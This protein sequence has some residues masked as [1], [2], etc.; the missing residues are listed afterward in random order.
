[1]T[2]KCLSPRS[3]LLIAALSASA[4]LGACKGD[5]DGGTD[6]A[7][8][9][10]AKDTGADS[11]V[12]DLGFVDTGVT[13]T[14]ANEDAGVNLC[15]V[16][17]TIDVTGTPIRV[18]EATTFPI[19]E[20]GA[21][22]VL[23]CR[24]TPPPTFADDYCLVECVDF[25]GYTPTAEE[26]Q[27]IEVA[28]F[29]LFDLTTMT[30]VSPDP[31]YD[32][33]TG[34]DH[35]PADRVP[36]GYILQSTADPQ[37]T[38]GYQLELGFTGGDGAGAQTLKAET[39][40]VLRIRSTQTSTPAWVDTYYWQFVRRN[41]ETP[42]VPACGIN[43]ARTPDIRYTFPI[44]HRSVLQA[45]IS[46]AGAPIPGSANLDDGFG[47][48]YAAL[49]ARDCSS[50]GGIPMTNATLGMT[51][52]PIFDVYPG[53][54][55]ELDRSAL[56]T[57]RI[58]QWVGVGFSEMTASSSMAL[59]VKAAVGVTTN[60]TCTQAFAGN[61]FPVYPDALTFV[62]FNRENAIVP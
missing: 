43:E 33:T 37:C 21:D 50:G 8:D 12:N 6:A 56:F 18:D 16:N 55:Y 30:P 54:A 5:D 13:D 24:H 57:S 3:L 23:S 51:P 9:T 39:P 60:E 26:V 27:Q 2:P 15:L 1:M 11:G 36:I 31:T 34:V 45:A 38:S 47:S 44:F 35:D 46:T 22:A 52:T 28:V 58:G 49:E 17:D 61:V 32:R 40:Y 14:G 48:G 29:P 42:D 19:T 4:T 10:G 41:D 53:P 20:S 7:P 62:T 59:D 25:L